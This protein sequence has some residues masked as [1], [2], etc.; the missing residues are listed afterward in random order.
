MR[1][2]RTLVWSIADPG[3]DLRP[4]QYVGELRELPEPE[5]PGQWCDVVV[6]DGNGPMRWRLVVV[7]AGSERSIFE[8]RRDLLARETVRAAGTDGPLD[9]GGGNGTGSAAGPGDRA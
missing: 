1:Q 2:L 6:E 9:A 7:E 5:L 3:A 8:A 4:D